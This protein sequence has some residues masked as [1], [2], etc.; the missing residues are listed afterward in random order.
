MRP[1][2]IIKGRKYWDGHGSRYVMALG[3][4]K[5]RDWTI[6]KKEWLVVWAGVVYTV[7]AQQ[8]AYLSPED[9]T[10]CQDLADAAHMDWFQYE[11]LCNDEWNREYDDHGHLR[12][13]SLRNAIKVLSEGL[14][15]QNFLD[16]EYVGGRR[17]HS[18]R[19]AERDF[20]CILERLGFDDPGPY[21]KEDK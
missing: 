11:N 15:D 12:R 7:K 16:I 8:L 20:R 17:C 2:L 10:L 19:T 13:T 5:K 14:I 18:P 6:D 3:P 1:G 4:M 9:S 21:L